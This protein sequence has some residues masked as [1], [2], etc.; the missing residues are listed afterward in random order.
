MYKLY[1]DVNNNNNNNK[2]DK[3]KIV[4]T[5]IDKQIY[6]QTLTTTGRQEK[7][8]KKDGTAISVTTTCKKGRRNGTVRPVLG[9]D[10]GFKVFCIT[11]QYSL[12]SVSYLSH[13]YTFH[14]QM[15]QT[16]QKCCI[17]SHLQNRWGVFSLCALE[18]VHLSSFVTFILFSVT[19]VARIL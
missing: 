14:S 1:N 15:F 3:T 19:F 6:R 10:R 12:R 2:K 13:L 17:I 4:L 7:E 9:G 11:K 16:D 8:G 18:K 5:R